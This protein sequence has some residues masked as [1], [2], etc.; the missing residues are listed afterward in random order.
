MTTSLDGIIK[1]EI[2]GV[3]YTI[4]LTM[5]SF[6]KYEDLTNGADLMVDL[7]LFTESGTTFG[8]TRI[9]NITHS[10]LNEHH[11]DISAKEVSKVMMQ[12]IPDVLEAIK[13]GIPNIFGIEQGEP[14][15]KKK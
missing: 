7:G 14:K 9:R 5:E 15:A 10:L 8:Y 2:D 4:Q 3:K 6:F 12:M 1:K 13:I 11:P